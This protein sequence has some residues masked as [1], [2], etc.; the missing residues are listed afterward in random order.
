MGGP[1]PSL[2]DIATQLEPLLAQHLGFA[3]T[4]RA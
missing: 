4:P 2:I 1:P 3:L